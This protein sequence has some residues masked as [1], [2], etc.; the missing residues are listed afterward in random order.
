MVRFLIK[1]PI[2]VVA[3]LIAFI[4]LGIISVIRM[5]VSLLPDIDIP[6]ISI[7]VYY[8]DIGAR[9]LENAVVMPLRRNLLQINGLKDI[10][11]ETR[12][13]GAIITLKFNHGTNIHYAYIEA[14]EKIDAMTAAFPRN[15]PRPTVLKK[16]ASDIPV[17]YLNIVYDSNSI[18]DNSTFSQLSSYA[19]NVIKRR[20]EQLGE[21]AMVDIN[22]LV[23]TV[24]QIEPDKSKMLSLGISNED[25]YSIL[26]KNNINYGSLLFKDGQYRYQVRFTSKL[27]TAKDISN[28]YLK[29]D[30][31]ILQIKDIA[32]VNMATA[33][34]DSYN[35]YNNA[36]GITL[37]IYKQSGTRMEM[38]RE[39]MLEVVKE[40]QLENS[41]IKFELGRDQSALLSYSLKNLKQTLLL[42]MI[43]AVIVMFFVMRNRK[44]PWLIAIS[45][46]ASLII[47]LFFMDM[48]SVSINIIS[49]SGLILG[50]GMMIDNSIIVID[51]INQYREQKYTINNACIL[52]TNEVIRPLISSVL[53]TCAVFVPLVFL[54]G[55][56][57]SLFID[58]A[59][60]VAI[61]LLVSLFISIMVLP[62]LFRLVHGK[63]SNQGHFIEKKMKIEL[64][65][66]KAL[67][68]VLRK[69]VL[70]LVLFFMLIPIGLIFFYIVDKQTFPD[71]EET[72]MQVNLEWNEPVNPQESKKRVLQ[73]LNKLNTPVVTSTVA[74]GK[75]Q[76][77]LTGVTDQSETEASFYF[78]TSNIG[79]LNKLKKELTTKIGLLFPNAVIKFI[80]VDNI[81][82]QIFNNDDAPLVAKIRLQSAE[83]NNNDIYTEIANSITDINGYGDKNHVP[84]VGTSYVVN[85]SFERLL[86]YGVD[87]QKLLS[88]LKALLS[89]YKIGSLSANNKFVDIL[90]VSENADLNTLIVN[91]HVRNENNKLI[92][93]NILVSISE[94]SVLKIISAD[95][96]G[97]YFPV[98]VEADFWD[99]KT[100][101]SRIVSMYKVD[102]SFTLS[103]GGSIF[104]RIELFREFMLVWFVSILLLYFILAAQFESL[105]Q[106]I[107]VLLEVMF[108]ISGALI[109]LV[110]F[111][112]S[113]NVMSA[114]GIVVMSGIVINDS[115]LKIDT[116]NR[117]YRSGSTLK[118]AIIQGGGRRFKPIVMTS[119]TTILALIPM[120]FLSGMGVDLQLPLALSVIGGLFI[121]TFVSLFFIP[122]FYFIVFKKKNISIVY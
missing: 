54:S 95:K 30:N 102:D 97:E 64:L 100:V 44:L 20:V 121:G 57:G 14:N 85:I 72:E 96:L 53:T 68:V 9:Q 52:G 66:E 34:P 15:M 114:I 88:K 107:I 99:Y 75:S 104:D 36:D 7:R 112:S 16:A 116:I 74:I 73:L 105:I 118:Q 25:I 45:I 49:L 82:H 106:P 84:I 22:G 18:V 4:A 48:F 51:N 23:H 62:V 33:E 31:R 101:I 120:L 98:D 83:N 42:G 70:F 39:K 92:P 63:N 71:I 69:R 50:V 40:L 3:T 21:V 8:P 29:R 77:M 24:V 27:R 60:A 61:S 10:E 111:N 76:F 1:R 103:W 79:H 38:V 2:A 91:E 90:I 87:Y 43:L 5:P 41:G 19:E 46:P 11:S 56:A 32:N 59:L 37:A 67:L 13:A 89:N 12:D 65:Y 17:F 35:I 113:L 108:D 6:E 93:L 94:Q 47:S 115:I 110:I 58:Q 26:S 28:I 122:V 119:I 109:M 117:V 55:I 86:M 78:S 81:F 80:P